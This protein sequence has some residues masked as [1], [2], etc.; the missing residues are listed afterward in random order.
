[1][2][3]TLFG[4][5]LALSSLVS[6][7]QAAGL[8]FSISFN[9]GI[10]YDWYADEEWV[11]PGMGIDVF[12]MKEPDSYIFKTQNKDDVLWSG[13]I[14]PEGPHSYEWADT[15]II[16]AYFDLT[17]AAFLKGKYI[18]GGVGYVYI[19]STGWQ[20]VYASLGS[21][22]GGQSDSNLGYDATFTNGSVWI[23][24]SGTPL[25]VNSI[26]LPAAFWML[27]AGLGALVAVRRRA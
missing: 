1:M 12:A 18:G 23:S 17:N 27:A 4:A 5:A 20:T 2:K 24:L 14:F 19:Y 8:S 7:A 11:I 10:L 3:K 25:P 13:G 9:K 26:P 15:D 22:M 21:R 16:D 6:P